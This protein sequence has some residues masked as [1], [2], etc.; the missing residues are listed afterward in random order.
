[1]PPTLDVVIVTWNAGPHLGACL[2]ALASADRAG[3]ELNRV[4]IV[5][6]AS[7]DGACDA[8]P[9]VGLPLLVI[10]NQSNRGFGAACNQGASDSRAG[11]LLFLNPDTEVRPDALERTVAFMESDRA[12][13]VGICGVSLVDEGGRPG[14]LGGRHPTPGTF[15]WDATGLARLWP[16]RFP[17]LLIR[18]TTVDDVQSIDSVTGAFLLIRRSLFVRLGGFDERFFMYLEDVDLSLRARDASARSVVLGDVRV[19]HA[20]GGS[21]SRVPATRLFYSLRSRLL[22][23]TLHYDSASAAGLL[24]VTLFEA[25]PRLARA[26][27]RLSASEAW[28]VLTAYARLLAELP[29]LAR[30]RRSVSGTRRS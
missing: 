19:V 5:D 1:M 27:S 14:I 4:V 23:G 29:G 16:R 28:A 12:R 7:A 8:L 2:E 3:F 21:S 6:N 26:A 25:V 20:E 11:Y 18:P 24:A 17:G 22:Y 10:R 15:L 13:D 30:I 9:R